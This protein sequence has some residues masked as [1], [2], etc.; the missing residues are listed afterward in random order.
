MFQN[1]EESLNYGLELFKELQ[2]RGFEFPRRAITFLAALALNQNKPDIA[3]EIA[4]SSKNVRYID[5][6]CI[7]LEAF[8][9]LKRFDEMLVFFRA[10]IFSDNPTRR[11]EAYFSDTVIIIINILL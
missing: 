10:S 4:S 1:T 3:L 11:K 6:R 9:R 7:K 8:A 5:V 2:A